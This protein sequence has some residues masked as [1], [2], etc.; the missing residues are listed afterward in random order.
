M[1]S[2]LTKDIRIDFHAR[3]IAGTWTIAGRSDCIQLAKSRNRTTDDGDSDDWQFW[4]RRY[5]L[6]TV[7]D[8]GRRPTDARGGTRRPP[9]L[10]NAL[11]QHQQQQ[12]Q[13][14]SGRDEQWRIQGVSGLSTVAI[15]A[16]RRHPDCDKL[17]IL[18][19]LACLQ[20]LFCDSVARSFVARCSIK[21]THNDTHTKIEGYILV[22]VSLCIMSVYNY[23][24]L[25]MQMFLWI[26]SRTAGNF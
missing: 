4:R 12:Q 22:R 9:S 10:G 24:Y 13:Q 7:V 3:V 21:H 23:I 5:D 1:C 15:W 18:L 17:L 25:Q 11:Q 26:T 16:P 6:A 2:I 20:Q 8:G 14:P 19:M